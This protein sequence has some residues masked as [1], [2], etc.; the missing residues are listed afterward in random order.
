MSSLIKEKDAAQIMMKD[1]PLIILR[2]VENFS[3]WEPFGLTLRKQ[4]N[5][6]G[7]FLYTYVDCSKIKA[8]QIK[9]LP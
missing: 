6:I 4:L 5:L 8:N 1:T 3:T 9:L 7:F 2:M